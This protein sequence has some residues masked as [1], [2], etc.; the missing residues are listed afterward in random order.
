MRWQSWGPP[1]TAR[2][3]VPRPCPSSQPK[4]L[5]VE[6]PGLGGGD[7]R[8]PPQVH[9][10]E[11]GLLAHAAGEEL[12]G[13]FKDQSLEGPGRNK[14]PHQSPGWWGSVD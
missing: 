9:D 10:A 13:L 11:H 8:G 2:N 7:S 6:T 5:S 12:A 1:P 3:Q 4:C 14:N